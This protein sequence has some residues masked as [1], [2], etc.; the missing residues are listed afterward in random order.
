FAQQVSDGMDGY[1]KGTSGI[2]T[3]NPN[4]CW[5]DDGEGNMMPCRIDTGDTAWMLTASSFVLFMTPG[6]AFFYGGLSRSKNT[7]NTVG[8]TFIIIG[9][10]AF[11]WVV[12]GYSLAFGPIDNDANLFMGNLDYVGLNQVSHYAPLGTPGPCTDTWS[13]AYQMQ[14]FHEDEICSQDW[15]GTVPHQLFAAF[16][17]T[18]AII[19]PALIV[20][21]LIDRIKFS[22]LIIFVLLWGTFV[23][24]PIAH[25]VWGGG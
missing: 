25:W 16:Q 8:M 13:A 17:G 6:V 14:V 10:M 5:F 21:G 7:V 9:L 11:Q 1:V 12:F 4:E 15:P 24:D 18:F 23:Y 19:T 2:Y 22:A 3:G 20:G